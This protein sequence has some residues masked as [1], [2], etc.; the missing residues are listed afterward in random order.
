MSTVTRGDAT[1]GG[2]GSLDQARHAD[3]LK[4]AIQDR[5]PDILRQVPLIDG[6]PTAPIPVRVPIL[7]WPRLRPQPP[8]E[9]P[10]AG[11]GQGP[12]HP[13]DVVGR[14]ARPAN[15]G[16]A[17]EPG[18]EPGAHDV[19]IEMDRATL[20]AWVFETLHLPA[21]QPRAGETVLTA[22]VWRSRRRHGP[23]SLLA[24]RATLKAALARS[25]A[26]QHPLTFHPD[27]RRYRAP[28]DTPT[29]QAQAVVVL[30]RDISGSMAGDRTYL[31][32]VLAW[33]LVAWVRQ[34]Y[35]TI[36]LG[37]WVHDT[38]AHDVEGEQ[39]WF[40]LTAGGGTLAAPALEAVTAWR[41]QHYPPSAW[42]AYL[43]HVTD[44]EIGDPET[45]TATAA[46]W[47]PVWTRW[48]TVE[49]QP[50]TAGAY[51]GWRLSRALGAAHVGPTVR[52]AQLRQAADVPT[53][54]R[55]LLQEDTP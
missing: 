44:G 53:V 30:L 25:L 3:R 54:L 37:W 12:G 17:G 49:I 16:G 43:L 21:L 24:R 42:D 13:G 40:G 51:D 36:R 20:L 9:P 33:W 29:P 10:T 22:P 34:Q 52:T 7:D 50:W 31:A 41:R 2:H 28:E 15:G 46:Q 1:W 48:W 45:V 27:D 19:V 5:L 47:A 14:R 11:V 35:P 32:R 39:A 18:R 8:R 6:D 26:Q 4:K 23:E 55:T 38:V